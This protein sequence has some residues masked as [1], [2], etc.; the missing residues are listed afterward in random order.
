MPSMG[1]LLHSAAVS[2]RARPS[3]RS[4]PCSSLGLCTSRTAVSTRLAAARSGTRAD[5][6]QSRSRFA[7]AFAFRVSRECASSAK[8][9]CGVSPVTET[10]VRELAARLLVLV[11]APTFV[12]P[13]YVSE[14]GHLKSV[15]KNRK[16]RP[17][18]GKNFQVEG[19]W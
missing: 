7:F 9:I 13:R 2:C 17:R 16:K 8:Q 15:Q 4:L 12:R 19:P 5:D 1:L 18:G 6:A 11:G 14:E 3:S 10:C